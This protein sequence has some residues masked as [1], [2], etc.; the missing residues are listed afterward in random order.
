MRGGVMKIAVYTCITDAYDPLCPPEYVDRRLN[1][2]YFSDNPSHVVEPW[3]FKGIDLP[4]PNAKDQS[5]YIKMHPHKVLPEYD[6]TL[7]IDGSI[8]IVGDIYEMVTKTLQLEG[9]IFLYDHFERNC[10][11]SEAAVCANI[12]HDWIWT[13]ARQMSRYSSEGYPV[14]NGLYESGAIIRRNTDKV[15]KLMEYW[16]QEYSQGAKRDQLS[17]PY[18]CWK[19]GVPISSMGRVDYRFTRHY[20]RIANHPPRRRSLLFISKHIF[21]RLVAAIFPY[22]RL[23]L[24]K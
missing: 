5:R 3:K 13:I 15:N 9:D 8:H 21:N 7:Y 23:F 20:F 1:Y 22:N 14:D 10:I 17:L 4:Y 24:I 6:V 16:W 2:F 12:G 18:V 11:Y 19:L